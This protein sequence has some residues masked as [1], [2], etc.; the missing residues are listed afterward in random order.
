MYR[1]IREDRTRDAKINMPIKLRCPE[2]DRKIK[3][4]E[5]VSPLVPCPSGVAERG[6]GL[7]TPDSPIPSSKSTKNRNL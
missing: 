1:L 3:F 4:P 7:E 6:A 5:F 2:S